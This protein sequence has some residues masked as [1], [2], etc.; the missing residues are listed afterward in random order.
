MTND[1]SESLGYYAELVAKLKNSVDTL[2]TAAYE[3]IG[4]AKEVVKDSGIFIIKVTNSIPCISSGGIMDIGRYIDFHYKD[5]DE[6]KNY[7]ARI[8]CTSAGGLKIEAS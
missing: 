2:G 5:S 3:N 1:L 7:D 8:S 4:T 6:G